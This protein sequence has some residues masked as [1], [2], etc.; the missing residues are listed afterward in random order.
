MSKRYIYGV[1][2]II[3]VIAMDFYINGLSLST[4]INL[5]SLIAVSVL[6]L[7]ISLLRHEPTSV[8]KSVCFVGVDNDEQV[9]STIRRSFYVASLFCFATSGIGIANQYA[10]LTAYQLQSAIIVLFLP[11]FYAFILAEIVYSRVSDKE[12]VALPG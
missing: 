12:R 3:S 4:F 9:R 1:S 2:V 10:S 11:I 7:G 6:A 5:P 8:L